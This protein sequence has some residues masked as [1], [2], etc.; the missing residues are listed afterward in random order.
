MSTQAQITDWAQLCDRLRTQVAD[1]VYEL[2]DVTDARYQGDDLAAV[3]AYATKAQA[4]ATK[5]VDHVIGMEFEAGQI[6]PTRK[7]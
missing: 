4:A 2:A 3:A 1:V 7:E 6:T 5:L